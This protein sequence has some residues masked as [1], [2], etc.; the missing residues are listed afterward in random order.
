MHPEV[1]FI[2]PYFNSGATI[3]ETLNSI[4]IQSYTN[5]DVWIVNDG[6]TDINSIEILKT[7]EGNPR[8]KLLD[9]ENSGPS[10]ARNNA[11]K[12]TKSE[13]IVPL[14]ADDLILP[15]A[16]ET[17][18]QVMMKDPKIGVVYGNFQS[19]G[20]VNEVKIQSEFSI[21][22]QLLWNQIAACCLIR[23]S[24]FDT[25]GYY[26]PYLSKLG[27]EDWEL[28]IRVYKSGFG[29]QK[30]EELFF[31]YRINSNSRTF[32]EANQRLEEIKQYV[33]KK[34]SALIMEQYTALYYQFKMQSELREYRIGNFILRPFRF[35]KSCI[36]LNPDSQQ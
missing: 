20:E 27:L 19:F 12:Q 9:Q 24:V 16:L 13:F 30:I 23:K 4:W 36:N 1:S 33:Y 3:M 18:M 31:A 29:F 10:I 5:Y 32:V 7:L 2:I 14:D 35:L 8:I 25:S 6:S 21:Q 17:A 15:N 34:H 28:W 26:D 22:Q 11:I